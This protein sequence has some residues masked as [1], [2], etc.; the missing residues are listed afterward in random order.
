[1]IDLACPETCPYLI[2]ARRSASQRETALRMK[3]TSAIDPRKL[4]LSDRSLLA[5][6]KV[7]SAIVNVRRGV[8]GA[9]FRDLTDAEILEA[10]ENTIRN[11]ETEESG[12]IYEHRAAT[13][14]IGEVSGRIRDA[15]ENIDEKVPLELRPRR[16]D[17]VKALNFARDTV[18]AHLKRAAGEDRR[19][20]IRYV[21]LFYP[22][23]EE[24]TRSLIV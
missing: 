23:P 8:E 9:A 16:S 5:L 12:L 22:W 21:A 4:L 13:P 2:E 17:M 7:E 19:S 1:M 3:E 6:D 20:Y 18:N 24:A 15:L 14:R 10:I 11:L